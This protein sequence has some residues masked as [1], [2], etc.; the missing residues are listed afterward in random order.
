MRTRYLDAQ[1]ELAMDNFHVRLNFNV[2]KEKGIRHQ[3]CKIWL[4]NVVKLGNYSVAK[5]ANF[6]YAC[7]TCGNCYHFRNNFCT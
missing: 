7:I 5:F 2:S 1:L 6:V 4:R 3:N